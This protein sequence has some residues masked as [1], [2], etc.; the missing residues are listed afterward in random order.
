VLR[1]H[2]QTD[3]YATAGYPKLDYML[4]SVLHDERS[5][6]CTVFALN[7]SATDS[8]QL[9]VELRGLGQRSLVSASELH[10][11]D[12]KAEN[13]RSSPEAVKPSA[14]AGVSVDGTHLQATLRPLS[15]N[16]FVTAA[17]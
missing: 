14:H 10:H 6:H 11:A 17:A 3:S 13:T 1:T 16:V 12:L 7:R 15:W 2:T 4:A 8:M 9:A 5:G